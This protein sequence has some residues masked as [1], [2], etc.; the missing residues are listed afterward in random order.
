[1][2][3]QRGHGKRF[4]LGAQQGVDGGE[5]GQVGL[6]PEHGLKP[7]GCDRQQGG[8]QQVE[9]ARGQGQQSATPGSIQRIALPGRLLQALQ[10]GGVRKDF[11]PAEGDAEAGRVRRLPG[12]AI[13]QMEG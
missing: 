6:H 8:G 12:R 7:L 3:G 1:M 10:H 5:A 9:E 11:I 13:R 4:W 2:P